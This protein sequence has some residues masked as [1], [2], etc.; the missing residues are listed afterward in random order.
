[1][2]GNSDDTRVRILALRKAYQEQLPGK[3]R[4]LEEAWKRLDG[5][6]WNSEAFQEFHRGVHTLAGSGALFG[7]PG[8][9]TS[10]RSLDNLL[11]SLGAGSPDPE[12]ARLVAAG[13]AAIKEAAAS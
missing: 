11:R 1:M 7:Y 8:V 13:L 12:T 5:G 2:P 4:E 3:L 9:S 6:S 10:A